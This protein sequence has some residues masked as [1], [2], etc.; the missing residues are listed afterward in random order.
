[1]ITPNKLLDGISKPYVADMGEVEKI[2]PMDCARRFLTKKYHS[3]KELQKDNN[4]GEI[5]YEEEYD[6]TPYYLL[7]K[8]A[9]K[10]KSMVNELFLEFLAENL[11]QKHDCPPSNAK[12]LAAT[13][14]MGKKKI[15]EGEYAILELRPSLPSNV[16]ESNLTEKEKD[17]INNESK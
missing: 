17:E 3:I 4:A 2:K 14:I 16:D 13:L 8:Y 11:I 1:L 12:E 9:D 5:Y 7:K 6:D 15:S 10:K